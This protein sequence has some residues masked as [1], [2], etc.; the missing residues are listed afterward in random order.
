MVS[1]L[2]SL[3]QDTTVKVKPCLW[4]IIMLL[5]FFLSESFLFISN[6]NVCGDMKLLLLY[7][8]RMLI[9]N[10]LKLKLYNMTKINKL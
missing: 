9:V 2:L 5:K 8:R 6:V 7:P 1:T 3:T 10:R 4:Q